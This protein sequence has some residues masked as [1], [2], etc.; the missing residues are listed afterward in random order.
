MGCLPPKIAAAPAELRKAR[1]SAHQRGHFS[2]QQRISCGAFGRDGHEPSASNNAA[3]WLEF[4]QLVGGFLPYP[5]EK[6]E[7][8]SL[9][10]MSKS[11]INGYKWAIFN[12]KLLV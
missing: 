3:S 8:V 11:T 7:S 1:F 12:S 2:V 4:H 9:F 6:Y 5:S 10:F